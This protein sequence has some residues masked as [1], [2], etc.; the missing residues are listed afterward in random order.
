ML[1]TYF[2]LSFI[3]LMAMSF[4][5]IICLIPLLFIQHLVYKKVL[6]PTYFNKKH[7]SDYEIA[8]FDSF[9]LFLIKTLGYI[10]AIVFPKTMRRK[11]ENDILNPKDNPVIYVLAWITM[12]IIIFGGLVLIN[13]GV[14]AIFYYSNYEN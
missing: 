12:L 10:K 4:A 8:I 5:G 9:P 13:T 11:F 3:L 7:Y 2:K 1:D 6:D 14:V